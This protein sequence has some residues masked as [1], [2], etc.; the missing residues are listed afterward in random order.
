MP[1]SFAV[2]TSKSMHNP[3]KMGPTEARGY[4]QESP[5][6]SK[7]AQGHPRALEGTPR[8]DQK[9][10][11]RAS[12]SALEAL[13]TRLERHWGVQEVILR[14]DLETKMKIDRGNVDFLKSVLSP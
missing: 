2:R 8:D 5:E 6:R 9:T 10:S 1:S 11:P 14:G 13:W 7:T 12:G 3:L 4:P